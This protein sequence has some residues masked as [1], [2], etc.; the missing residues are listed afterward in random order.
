MNVMGLT[1]CFPG[2]FKGLLYRRSQMPGIVKLSDIRSESLSTLPLNEH[3]SELVSKL[4]SLDP[5]ANAAVRPPA[6]MFLCAID[7]G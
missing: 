5:C 3:S 1:N 6:E 7:V 4:V 2:W